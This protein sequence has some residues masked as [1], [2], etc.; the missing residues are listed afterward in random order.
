[1][2]HGLF[3]CAAFGAT[4]L[5]AGVVPRRGPSGTTA[6]ACEPQFI[7]LQTGTSIG[8]SDLPVWRK[9]QAEVWQG[10][11][12]L[13]WRS[14]GDSLVSV[15]LTLRQ[16]PGG[17]EEP[18][19]AVE[20]VPAVDFA[21]RCVPG[22]TAGAI[23]SAPQVSAD[24]LRDGAFGVALR[25]RDYEILVQSKRDDLADARVMLQVGQKTQTLYFTDESPDEP[26]YSVEWAGDLDRDGRLDL[27]V[28]LNRKYSWH[29]YRLLLSSLASPSEIVGEA[30]VFEDGD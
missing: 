9:E 10:E 4:L 5:V 7:P 12:W 28:N 13:G 20:I 8:G 16:L 14:L 30:A 24:L 6:K 23:Y 25:D 3:L 26:H 11:G 29:P 22:L 19:L 21:V 17:P 27:V 15:R 2:R 1:M 18:E